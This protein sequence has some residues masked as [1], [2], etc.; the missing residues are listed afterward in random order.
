MVVLRVIQN[1]RHGRLECRVFKQGKLQSGLYHALGGN[2]AMDQRPYPISILLLFFNTPQHDFQQSLCHEPVDIP[3]G[4]CPI[5]GRILQWIVQITIVIKAHWRLSL[6]LVLVII[7]DIGV[8]VWHCTVNLV[9]HG[10][11]HAKRWAS[12]APLVEQL[13]RWH[14]DSLV[15]I[16]LN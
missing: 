1:D 10:H 15:A 5:I 13:R 3:T 7:V 12:I 11:E 2:N 8:T 6:I 14:F 9:S 4:V 16:D